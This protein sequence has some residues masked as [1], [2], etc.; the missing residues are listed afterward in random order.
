MSVIVLGVYLL[1]S[2]GSFTNPCLRCLKYLLFESIHIIF[3]FI[4]RDNNW[5]NAGEDKLC[6]KKIEAR[7]PYEVG[8]AYTLRVRAVN[9][10]GAGPWSIESD[11]VICKYKSLKPK[12][13]FKGFAS[14]EAVNFK[15]G[16]TMMF[17]ADIEGKKKSH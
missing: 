11:Q 2:A 14:K 5:F 9:A 6:F 7:G 16:E 12:V 8:Q 3:Y 17:E 1:T 4:F 10:A 13:S 15:A